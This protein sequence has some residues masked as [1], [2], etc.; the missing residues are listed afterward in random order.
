M[1]SGIGDTGIFSGGHGIWSRIYRV[2]GVNLSYLSHFSVILLTSLG[3]C[4]SSSRADWIKAE[5]RV[6]CRRCERSTTTTLRGICGEVLARRGLVRH[7]DSARCSTSSCSRIR[8]RLRP[9]REFLMFSQRE[10]S[11]SRRVDVDSGSGSADSQGR[12]KNHHVPRLDED[13]TWIER[14]R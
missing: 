3:K 4:T 13:L 1:N 5:V 12:M 2:R 8:Y 10:N 9:L 6:S 11:R 14:H 7:G